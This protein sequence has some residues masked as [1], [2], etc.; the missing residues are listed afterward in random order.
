VYAKYFGPKTHEDITIQVCELYLKKMV[1]EL[2]AVGDDYGLRFVFQMPDATEEKPATLKDIIA[3]LD[4]VFAALGLPLEQARISI[5]AMIST[6]WEAGENP[7]DPKIKDFALALARG[8]DVDNKWQAL[9]E[10]QQSVLL[11]KRSGDIDDPDTDTGFWN[12]LNNWPYD[13]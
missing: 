6:C 9:S 13:P 4:K 8:Y 2:V 3:T 12:A 7:R 10:S 1:P 11:T 5:N